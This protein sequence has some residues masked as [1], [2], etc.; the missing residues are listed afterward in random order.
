[1]TQ[2]AYHRT[3]MG[4][5]ARTALALSAAFFCAACSGT[6]RDASDGPSLA[7]GNSST[8]PNAPSPG[9]STPQAQPPSP[10]PPPASD[11][12]PPVSEPTPPTS[13][14]PAA[15]GATPVAPAPMAMTGGASPPEGE[16]SNPEPPATEEPTPPAESGVDPNFLVFL[17]IGQSNMEGAPASAAEDRN[18]NPRVK[19]LALRDCP[20]RGQLRNTWYTASPSLHTCGNSLGPGD[21][22]GK[23]LADALPNATIGLVP[24]AIAGVD[25]DIFRK[26]VVSQ[27]RSEF[28][29]PPDNQ[30]NSAYETLIERAR[31]AQ[32]VGVVRGI[33]FHQGE[34]DAATGA[35][36][37]A[38]PGKVQGLV[39]DIRTDLGLNSADVPFLAGELLAN[40][41]PQNGCCG[42][43]MNPLVRSLPN[44]IPN[45]FVISGSGLGVNTDGLHYNLAGQREF[46][47]RYG[48][49]MLEALGL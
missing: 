47:T 24:D 36:Q 25:I 27:R 8:L 21:Y 40:G 41:A 33:L 1:V 37:Q 14:A 23:V 45:A 12:A 6:G 28:F 48:Q 35:L 16:P 46:G 11:S 3:S 5:L 19:V 7:A 30:R 49:T 34:S 44:L 31:L 42:N 2:V 39:Q 20:Q 32:Q 13:E 15:A 26:G 4:T 22:F 38:W 43:A 29:L 10:E 17:L 9:G 18:Q